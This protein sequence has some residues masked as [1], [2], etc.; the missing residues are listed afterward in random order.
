MGSSAGRASLAPDMA[1]IAGPK[2][3]TE[4]GMSAGSSV[5]MTGKKLV[6][7]NVAIWVSGFSI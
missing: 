4:A 5:E 7:R 1:A 2:A 3:F 6:A